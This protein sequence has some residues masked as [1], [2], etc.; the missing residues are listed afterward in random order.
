MAFQNG[1]C[2][3]AD[4]FKLIMRI[5]VTG[6]KGMLGRTLTKNL[7]GHDLFL[8]D[9]DELNIT[10]SEAVDRAISSFS[11]DIV[12]HCAAMTQVDDCETGKD[13]AFA[14]NAT[15]S[16][17]VA[18][19][20]C[21]TGAH[22]IAISTDYVFSGELDRPY[23]EW[24]QTNPKTVYGTSK[25][26]GE[27]AVR[28]HCP[29]HTIIRIA[30]LYGQGGPSFYHTM[31]RLLSQKGKAL[32]VV[33]DQTGNPTST[34]V[35]AEVILQCLNYRITGT[36]NATTEGEATWYEFA[37]A[38]R[39]L[40]GFQREIVPCSTAEYPLPAPRPANSRLEN[41]VLRKEGLPLLPDWHS[42]LEAFI[43]TYPE[44]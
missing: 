42:A 28:D 40:H 37:Q 12:I 22:L 10:D 4:L 19:A 36:V 1:S 29:I 35:V 27:W 13:K 23:H 3:I 20:S 34:D 26:A 25:L 33:N 5:F 31:K 16:K 38:I 30:W 14:I 6:A 44:G 9:V 11:P 21:K 24:D 2:R 17:N 15:G 39:K 8:T 43:Q 32:T 18:I 41:R 7:V